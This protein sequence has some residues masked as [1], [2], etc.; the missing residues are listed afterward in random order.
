MEE[1]TNILNTLLNL[2]KI[3]ISSPFFLSLFFVLILTIVVLF[4]NTKLNKKFLKIIIGIAY[5]SIS[6]LT[7]IYYSSSLSNLMD[8]IVEKIMTALYFPNYI[9]YIC[10]ILISTI[11]F[12]RIIIDKKITPFSKTINI[13]SHLIII[14][15][16]ILTLDIITK[17]NINVTLRSEVYKN[18]ALL[19]LIESTTF[20]FAITII[21]N[22]IDVISTYIVKKNQTKPLKPLK[23]INEQP[24]I[25]TPLSEETFNEGYNKIHKQQQ[26]KDYQKI[27]SNNKQN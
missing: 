11:W 25:I 17:N 1:N 7:I 3:I 24:V 23:I 20:I 19:N 13:S 5:A 12:V 14:F 21:G 18:K 4:I 15:L 10:M 9:S 22:I 16:F 8:T 26:Y 27:A 2:F 6:I